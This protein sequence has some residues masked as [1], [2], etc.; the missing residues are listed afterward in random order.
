MAELIAVGLI[1]II[2]FFL[3]VFYQAGFEKGYAKGVI[4]SRDESGHTGA[5]AKQ[6][7]Q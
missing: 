6:E 2:G 1:L 4:D 5:S 7:E 3:Y